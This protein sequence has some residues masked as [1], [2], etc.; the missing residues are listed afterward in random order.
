MANQTY[1]PRADK[2]KVVWFKNFVSKLN[3]YSATLGFTAPELTAI[4]N[5]SLMLTYMVDMVEVFK[6]ESSKRVAYKNLLMHG[7]IGT[8]ISNVPA[9]PPLP[10]A[11]T[12]VPAG[13]F[14]R[15]AK[16]VQRIK[17]H[18]N[19]ND[20]IGQDLNI[21]APVSTEDV[22]AMKPQLKPAHDAGRPRI[23]WRKGEAD[24][25]DLY[26][27]R[28]D[29]KGFVFLAND[30]QPDYIDTCAVPS[31]LSSVVWDYKGIYKITDEHV[32]EFSDAISI[33]VTKEV[34]V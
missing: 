19:Y 15:M 11:P 8:P 9:V 16:T 3:L 28:H 23:K 24:S 25:I 6:S 7:E 2:D 1:L 33:T 17:N 4:S 10:A 32:G 34:M 27:D 20:A 21:I 31:G 29:G 12:A 13:V 30:S 5:D 14:K 18:S 22:S 26:V